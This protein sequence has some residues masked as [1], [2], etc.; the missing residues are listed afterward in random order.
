MLVLLA[1]IVFFAE[2]DEVDYWF[3][4][5]EEQRVDYLDLKYSCQLN[6]EKFDSREEVE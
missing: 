2:I 4:C 3:C 5:E 6:S 1:D